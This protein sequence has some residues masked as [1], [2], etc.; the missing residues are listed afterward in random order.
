MLATFVLLFLMTGSVVVLVKAMGMNVLPL[1]ASLG[2]VNTR[3]AHARTT[4]RRC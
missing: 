3:T 2:A 1:G 4:R